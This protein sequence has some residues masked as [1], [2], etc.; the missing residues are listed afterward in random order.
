MW[1]AFLPVAPAVDRFVGPGENI[2]A[3][4][5]DARDGDVVIV[6]PAADPTGRVNLSDVTFTVRSSGDEPAELPFLNLTGGVDLTLLNVKI[7]VE[8]LG[9]QTRGII[10]FDSVIRGEDV[11][12]LPTP[13]TDPMVGIY[14]V[15]GAVDL[16][17]VQAHGLD[18]WLVIAEDSGGDADITLRDCELTDI[19]AP[20]GGGTSGV[21]QLPGGSFTKTLT[22]DGCRIEGNAA[23]YPLIT[24]TGPGE[25]VIR[26][27]V[28][29]DNASPG[30]VPTAVSV[31]DAPVT[32]DHA[33]FC[34][35]GGPGVFAVVGGS[36][37]L[38]R[39]WFDAT[40]LDPGG[41]LVYAD[42]ADVTI[43]HGTFT[44]DP[45]PD[46]VAVAQ[47]LTLVNTLFVG[48][49]EPN[50]LPATLTATHTLWVGATPVWLAGDAD[51]AVASDAGFVVG[52]ARDGCDDL[53][54]PGDGSPAIDAG[55]PTEPLEDGDVGLPDV[56][57]YPA[58]TDTPVGPV[59]G[60]IVGGGG[61]DT[62]G[63][64]PGAAATLALLM[65]RWGRRS[66]WSGRT[67]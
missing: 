42:D 15:G 49:D 67:S 12:F 32:V 48:F 37:T 56:G 33:R 44:G 30:A 63:A 53:P 24:A 62:S 3:A 16:T 8:D 2:A 46:P 58:V 9:P 50:N 11:E 57:A 38:N 26:D 10:A 59:G 7:E 47:G 43:R 35:N 64:G 65:L 22:L 28:F 40:A 34:G 31:R 41:A 54:I 4:L 52:Y 25:V 14:L 21:V 6:D 13:T 18:G 45:G 60:F 23:V 20:R 55:D 61:C 5:S 19:G 66:S 29:A 17:R 27:T 39:T 51:L 36:A 1:L